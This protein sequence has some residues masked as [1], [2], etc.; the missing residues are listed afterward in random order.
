MGK[1]LNEVITKAVIDEDFRKIFLS[2]PEMATEKYN[3]SEE[4]VAQLRLIDMFELAQVNTELEERLSKTFINLPT[5]EY[6]SRAYTSYSNVPNKGSSHTD[7]IHSS[8]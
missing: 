1:N 2:N 8:W 4:E 7:V 5:I 3:L 6:N